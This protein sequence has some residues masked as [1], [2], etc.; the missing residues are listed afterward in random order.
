MC[1]LVERI[2][3]W[4]A[5][6]DRPAHCEHRLDAGVVSVGFCS[7]PVN[8]N[9]HHDETENTVA[10]LAR[11]ETMNSSEVAVAT[12][13]LRTA[14]IVD[15][16]QPI[17]MG[18]PVYPGHLTTAVFDHHTHQGTLGKFESDMSYATKGLILSDHG[19]T[20]VDSISH[21]DPTEG[22]PTI[23]QM[24][25]DTF[26]GEGTCIDIS[27]T[28]PREYCSADELDAALERS[29][30]ELKPEDVL[31]INTGTFERH[32]GTSDYL[33]EYPGL[34]ESGAEWLVD[35]K[36]KVFGVDSP[37]PDNPASPTYPV[38]LMCRREHITHYEN[39][40]HL[41]SLVGRRFFFVALPLQ[42][43]EGHGSPVRAVALLP[44]GA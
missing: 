38:H 35:R 24:P 30:A 10:A 7:L 1:D 43:Q 36:V 37:S 44:D 27:S 19:P 34:D 18:M 13:D 15:L 32:G 23:D 40:A 9:R 12:T 29:G 2:I 14:T 5:A 41:R 39:L 4:L 8:G 21:F 16:S 42:I 11:G 6:G 3:E 17:Y 22:A 33:S 25:L 26:C 20:H 31:L 28:G